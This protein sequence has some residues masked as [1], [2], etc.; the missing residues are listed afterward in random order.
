M[1]EFGIV[2]LAAGASTRM[3]QSKQLLPVKGEPLLLRSVNAAILSGAQK[4]VVV[5]GAN[6]KAHRDLIRDLKVEIVFNE[7]WETGMGSS[8]KTG[9]RALLDLNPSLEGIVVLVCDQP[10]LT[11]DHIRQLVTKHT[12]TSKPIV[13]SGYAATSGVPVFFHKVYF[14]KLMKLKDEQGAKKVIQQNSGDVTLQPFPQGE[15]DLDTPEDYERF[16]R[17]K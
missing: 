14:G 12:E 6:E 1:K 8:I 13:A 3:G 5:L 2:M 10:L 7:R 9:L 15:I 16:K 17:S 11:A 4:I